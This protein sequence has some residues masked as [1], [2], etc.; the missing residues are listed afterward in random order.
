MDIGGNSNN[1]G[2]AIAS[3]VAAAGI[4]AGGQL[5][6]LQA[7]LKGL[8]KSVK[9]IGLDRSIK[10]RA[11]KM[12]LEALQLEIQMV[13]QRIAALQSGNKKIGSPLDSVVADA[14]KEMGALKRKH[15]GDRDF[16]PDRPF[17]SIDISA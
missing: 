9:D 10:P 5:A 14:A 12:M 8:F 2:K 15:P 4:A 3:Q 17:P 7:K 6:A 11:K 1:I 13:M 16:D